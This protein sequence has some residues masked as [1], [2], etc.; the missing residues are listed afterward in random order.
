MG[1]T[2]SVYYPD[3]A[4]KQAVASIKRYFDEVLDD[5]IGDLKAE[6]MLDFILK[7]IAPTVYNQAI[8][9]AQK[10]M[11][12]RVTDMDSSLFSPEFAYWDKGAKRK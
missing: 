1:K 12:E 11:Q 2:T 4:R 5:D 6:L 8:Q 7:D 3:E 9:D 10:F